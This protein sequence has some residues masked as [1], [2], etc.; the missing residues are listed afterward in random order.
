MAV[1][2]RSK[3]SEFVGRILVQR[4]A[5]LVANFMGGPVFDPESML[6]KYQNMS[7]SLRASIRSAVMPLGRLTIG[8]ARHCAPLF[9][10]LADN[11]AVRC[12]LIKG[13]QYTGSDDGA[14]NIVKFNDGREYIV[15]LMSDAGTL[16]SSDGADLGREFEE[17]LFANNLQ[18]NKDDSNTQLGSS[19]SE[20]S[21]SVYGSF[22]NESLEKGSTPSNTGHSDPYGA[23]TGQTGNQGSVQ[24]SSF[25]ELPVST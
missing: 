21:S 16:I 8:L 11:L 22:E 1:E 6:L 23:T 7:S 10:V 13:R 17:S 20:A 2:F 25:G 15:D 18:V 14:L 3:T 19:F 24:S 5:I 4:L 9:K 12:R